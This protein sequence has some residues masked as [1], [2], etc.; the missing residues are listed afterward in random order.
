MSDPGDFCCPTNLDDK[1][2]EL[3]NLIFPVGLNVELS[4]I[5]VPD[6]ANA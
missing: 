3:P 6:H 4:A 2:G 5:S 1:A